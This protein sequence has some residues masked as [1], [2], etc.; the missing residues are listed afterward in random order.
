MGGAE[1]KED[2]VFTLALSWIIGGLAAIAIC[3]MLGYFLGITE[4]NAASW[5]QA[6]GSIG[7]IM[8]AWWLG[9]RQGEKQSKDRAHQ[10]I[11]AKITAADL[12][13]SVADDAVI[14]A[15]HTCTRF[16]ESRIQWS[17]IG[18]ERVEELQNAVRILL[19]KDIPPDLF[20]ALLPIQ[21]ELAYT[22]T[23]IRQFNDQKTRASGNRVTTAIQRAQ[24][25]DLAAKGIKNIAADY[26]AEI[27]A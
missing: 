22:F 1:M 18:I 17:E 7:A 27:G 3:Y 24:Q 8:F 26:R 13:V 10:I 20:S 2:R 12:C 6:F 15:N 19:S 21:R 5:T 9:E 14:V 23:A 16:Y 4:G 11:Q 25:I